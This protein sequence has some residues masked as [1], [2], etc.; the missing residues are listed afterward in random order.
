MIGMER[1][2]R[3]GKRRERQGEGRGREIREGKGAE[4]HTGDEEME[5]RL[6]A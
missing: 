1:G 2:R 4:S 3:I 6:Q 5:R